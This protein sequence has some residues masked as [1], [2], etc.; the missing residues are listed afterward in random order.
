MELEEY[1]VD[2]SSAWIGGYPKYELGLDLFNLNK[3]ASPE[4]GHAPICCQRC[5][6]NTDT[7]L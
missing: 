2:E 6:Q 5:P 1:V 7:R 3:F 4:D